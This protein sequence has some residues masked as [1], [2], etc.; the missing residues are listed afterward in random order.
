MALSQDRCILAAFENRHEAELAVD[1]LEQAG[2][3]HADVGLV[4]RGSDAVEGGMI[5]DADGAKDGIGLAA[6]AATGGIIGG[7]LGALAALTVPI[8]GPVIAG[9]VLAAALGFG[10]AGAM[11][12]GLIGA[13]YGLGVSEDEA[14]FYEKQF[15]AG[16]AIVSVHPRGRDAEASTILQRHGGYSMPG[17]PDGA[18]ERLTE[19][20]GVSASTTYNQGAEHRV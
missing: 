1:D 13:F 19:N 2:F 8:A 4:I 17:V 14:R 6:G 5:T 9:G 10:A 11:T 16:K 7:V 15:H 12:G 3:S 18:Y 20:S